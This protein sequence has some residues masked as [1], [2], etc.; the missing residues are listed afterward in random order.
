M[1]ILERILA[2]KKTEVAKLRERMTASEWEQS[3]ES[4]PAPKPF[5]ESLQ[6]KSPVA[7][8]AEIKKASPSK[9]VIAANFDPIAM[10]K[11]YE[12][13]GAS[14]LSVLTDRE[15]F[16]GSSNVLQ[17]VRIITQLPILRKD[18]IIDEWQV[19]ETRA[20]GA[21]AILLI[22]AALSD[23]RLTA[24]YKLALHLGLAP[25]IEVHSLHEW[26][27]I[28]PLYPRIVGVNHRDLHT[29]QVDLQ[30]TEKLANEVRDDVI[31]VSESG[32]RTYEDVRRVQSFGAQAILVGETLMR[33]GPEKVEQGIA[34]LLG[35]EQSP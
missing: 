25:L 6:G 30:L 24:L 10:A 23:E 14:A 1:T 19:Y 12:R 31:L 20:M 8:I 2:T 33:F 35:R 9:G 22:V 4:L 21:D 18:F 16:Q 27:R 3:I 28:R 17:S 11:G 13:A 29:F 5:V 34:Q 26:E 32:I 7:L 15:Y